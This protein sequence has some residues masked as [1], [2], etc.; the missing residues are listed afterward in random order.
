M[1][2]HDKSAFGARLKQARTEAR[3][4]QAEL[5]AM[6]QMPPST[7]GSLE[8]AS[9]TPRGDHLLRLALACNVSPWWLMFGTGPKGAR[10]NKM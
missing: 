4:T 3:L 10:D 8:H 7:I 9:H 2:D 1:S 5:A 6:A